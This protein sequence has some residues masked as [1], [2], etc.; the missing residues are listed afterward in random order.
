MKEIKVI[1]PKC[2]NCM[3]YKNYWSWI[4]Y[5]PIHWFNFLKWKD[6]RRTKCVNCGEVSYIGRE[7]SKKRKESINA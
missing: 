7:C 6:Y 4:W 2:G 5:T 1:C 3:T